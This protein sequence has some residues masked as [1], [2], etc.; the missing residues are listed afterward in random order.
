MDLVLS[1]SEFIRL[2][3]LVTSIKKSWR[4][5]ISLSSKKS[6]IYFFYRSITISQRAH[7]WTHD[8]SNPDKWNP[9][10]IN[11]VIVETATFIIEVESCHARH[12]CTIYD[13]IN[14]SYRGNSCIVRYLVAP[15]HSTQTKKKTFH[16]LTWVKNTAV[17][18]QLGR[19]NV[20]F[21]RICVAG[22]IFQF[23]KTCLF[24]HL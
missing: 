22:G 5:Y 4:C 12:T 9:H 15:T 16:W 3:A 21:K 7:H 13:G 11:I 18:F 14:L 19:C 1:Q 17:Y 8:A 20:N 10:P 2:I 24:V 23:G 6:V